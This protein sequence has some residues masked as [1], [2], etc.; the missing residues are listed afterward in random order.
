MKIAYVIS[1]LKIGGAEVALAQIA[2]RIKEKGHEVF[3]AFFHDGPIRAR[4]EAAGITTFCITGLLNRYD[5]VAWWRLSC[6]LKTN[7]IELIHTALWSANIIGRLLGRWHTLPVVSDLHGNCQAEG[8]LRNWGDRLTAQFSTVTIAVSNSVAA[9][10][11]K[12]ILK[13][14][15]LKM[16]T[17]PNAIETANIAN[18]PITAP[19]HR[20]SFNIPADAFVV[21]T[22]GRLEPI[23][24]YK[25]L[26]EACALL[27][28]TTY[29]LI[30][31]GGSC[32][33]EL[34]TLA[35]KK[36]MAERCII[37][38]FRNDAFRFYQLFDCFAIASHSE[39]LSLALLEAM[40]AACPVVTTNQSISH[41]VLIH[42]KTGL[43]ITQRAP[44][45]YAAL[46]EICASNPS[47]RHRIGKAA[48]QH[49]RQHHE[50]LNVIEQLDALYQSL[51]SPI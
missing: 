9:A 4:L 23:K 11:K 33:T 13:K 10:Y 19:L 35:K 26:I 6:W 17:I 48:Q 34:E 46:L 25:L 36:G 49:V 38:G 1:S 40:A 32:R 18:A 5:M 29:L 31:G 51:K 8:A 24:G 42:G 16:V 41:D 12:Y 3:V 37:T 7:R 30:V 44:S 47:L 45:H 2:P 50:L 15:I 39:G 21:G 28:A 43:I 20:S 14:R 22:V 27:P